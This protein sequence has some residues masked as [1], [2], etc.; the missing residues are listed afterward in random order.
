MDNKLVRQISAALRVSTP[1]IGIE[2]PDQAATISLLIQNV[3][4][5]R[6]YL[7]F[8]LSGG[9]AGLNELG[10]AEVEDI[11]KE[12][13]VQDPSQLVN[14]G[15]T[16]ALALRLR[17]KSVLFVA[18]APFLFDNSTCVQ[19]M[20][21][22]RDKF[23]GN[24]RC[25]VL[26]GGIIKLPAE[27]QNDV[28]LFEEEYPTAAELQEILLSVYRPSAEK[29]GWGELNGNTLE[30]AIDAL[31]GLPAFLAE[32]IVAMSLDKEK[33]LDLDALWGRKK[34]TIEQ[35]PGLSIDRETGTFDDVAGLENLKDLAQGL[36][37][38][39][40]PPKVIVRIEELEKSMA[41]ARKD[42]P[43]DSSGVSQDALQTLLNAMEDNNWRGLL[44]EGV[45]GSGKS[46]I[47]KVMGGQFSCL[48]ISADLGAMKASLVGES[49]AKVR[50][51]VKMVK[52]IAGEGGAFFVATSNGTG[53]L[54]PELIERFSFGRWEFD[55]P[56]RTQRLAIWK[57]HLAKYGMSFDENALPVDDNWVGR[58]IRN[59][60]E[61]AW[62]MDI[63]LKEASRF[64][65]ISGRVLKAS[66]STVSDS[67]RQV[68]LD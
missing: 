64:V 32:Q 44:A 8:D 67:Q 22:L 52:A 11:A 53:N 45:P 15:E 17:P 6:P 48:S 46:L 24:K 39:R 1:L 3:N 20:A 4:G 47:S 49:E 7:R 5:D 23:K 2:T 35:T 9:L 40:N 28:V 51:F 59:C 58:N 19:A 21:N 33:G 54:P 42:T 38:G 60:C 18:N 12:A 16:L 62:R 65:S 30:N 41:G 66:R 14:A 50:N 25:L 13:G 29:Y 10:K 61:L 27:L 57:I 26:L 63:S 56:D 43:G 31:R 34:K 36:F 55:R 37:T 68:D